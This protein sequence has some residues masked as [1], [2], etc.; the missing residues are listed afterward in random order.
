MKR[1]FC[2]LG[3]P[4]AYESP[5]VMGQTRATAASHSHSNTR[6]EPH[7]Q[8]SHSSEQC[9]IPDP[10]SKARDW[11]HILMD[12][13]GFFSTVPQRKPP[14]ENI[15]I[16]SYHYVNSQVFLQKSLDKKKLWPV[17]QRSQTNLI[18]MMISLFKT[19]SLILYF[20]LYWKLNIIP[21]SLVESHNQ[22]RLSP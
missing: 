17:N 14:G 7:L 2:F 9:W 4:T 15:V 22:V 1:N 20:A 16:L 13:S 19:P 12:T 18:Q 5:Q 21:K 11:T 8:P 6:S 3:P 10:L